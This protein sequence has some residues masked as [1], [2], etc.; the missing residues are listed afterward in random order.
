M[1]R[2]VAFFYL[3]LLALTTFSAKSAFNGALLYTQERIEAARQ[4]M[5]HDKE[6]QQGWDTILVVANRQLQKYDIMKADY[7]VL[8]W[9]MTGEQRYADCLKTMLQKAVERSWSN[10]EM[11]QR[12]PAWRSELRM[13]VVCGQTAVA[14]SAI[15]QQLTASERRTLSKKLLDVLVEPAL[16]DWLIEPTRIH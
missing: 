1:K 8:A 2:T 3:L 14:Y 5:Q 10:A 15:R 11:M 9:L 4:R 6:M 12:Q 16:G 7:V 13:A